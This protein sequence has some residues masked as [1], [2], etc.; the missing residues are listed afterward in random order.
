[1][2][3]NFE[4]T[5]I[6]VYQS[7]DVKVDGNQIQN[8]LSETR[9]S[10]GLRAVLSDDSAF[11]NNCLIQV[12]DGVN[13]SGGDMIIKDNVLR[14]FSRGIWIAQGNAVIEGN[15]LNP[16]AFEAAPESYA[17]SVTNNASAIIKNNTCKE[18][19][20]YPIYC[21]TSAKTSIIGN[22]FERSPLLVT[23]YINAGV[24]EIFDNTISVNRTAGNPI[25]IYINGSAGSI[26]SGN[27]INNLSA[28][29]ATAIQTN[30]STNSKIIGNRIFKGTINRHSSDTADGNIIA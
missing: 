6:L 4:N 20:N 1:K 10:T 18:F 13:I 27:T 22:H 23:I 3:S 28:G 5:G 11:L 21:S 16:D 14:K 19:K 8:G 17:V 9:R 25:V 24:H 15:T 7:S 30:T 2:I 12:I 29:T 26:I